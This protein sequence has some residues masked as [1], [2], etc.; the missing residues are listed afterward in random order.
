MTSAL[1][2]DGLAV[3]VERLNA[4]SAVL[5]ITERIAT[6]PPRGYDEPWV[7]VTQIDASN[8]PQSQFEHL[9]EFILQIDCYA[10]KTGGSVE[11]SLLA[12]TVRAEVIAMPHATYDDVVVSNARVLSMPSIPDRAIEPARER[13][14]LTASIHM[15][16][17]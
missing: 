14:A 15:H 7:R 1:I 8:S 4:S 16:P 9:I 2:P 3:V 6:S 11:A 10:G 12:R 5:A 13:Y 17:R